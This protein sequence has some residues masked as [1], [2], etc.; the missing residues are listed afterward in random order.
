[1]VLFIVKFKHCI[2]QSSYPTNLDSVSGRE[3]HNGALYIYFTYISQCTSY[4]TIPGSQIT[5][6]FLSVLALCTLKLTHVMKIYT[7]HFF[8]V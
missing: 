5:L 6:Q 3:K 1:M 4:P 8:E 7:L 2:F